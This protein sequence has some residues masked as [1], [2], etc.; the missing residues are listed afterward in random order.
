M[1]ARRVGVVAPGRCLFFCP[2]ILLWLD[3]QALLAVQHF[4]CIFV[5]LIVRGFLG[6]VLG[7]L[8]GCA[9]DSRWLLPYCCAA[10]LVTADGYCRIV[11]RLCL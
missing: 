3:E 7:L 9:C 6:F 8:C 5:W 10:V 11:V 4:I 2:T 1:F